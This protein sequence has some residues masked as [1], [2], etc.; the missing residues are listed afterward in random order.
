MRSCART[1][2]R[3]Y[4]ALHCVTDLLER[5][6]SA[7]ASVQNPPPHLAP[8]AQIRLT[9]HKGESLLTSSILDEG[10]DAH[11]SPDAKSVRCAARRA[12]QGNAGSFL[13]RGAAVC[14]RWIGYY[15]EVQNTWHCVPDCS[16][17]S[18]TQD[19]YSSTFQ[20]RSIGPS[21]PGPARPSEGPLESLPEVLAVLPALL[22]AYAARGE[23]IRERPGQPAGALV[24]S[25]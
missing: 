13:E 10:G 8:T 3:R 7:H 14:C 11:V 4:A 9:G 6:S 16:C 23:Q 2:S 24:A 12:G 5:S 22:N 15:P 17:C 1:A 20:Y 21:P 18:P 25:G 19:E